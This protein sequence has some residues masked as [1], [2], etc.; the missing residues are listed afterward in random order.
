MHLRG[1]CVCIRGI[2]LQYP[3]VVYVHISAGSL[4]GIVEEGE[5]VADELGN[6]VG[7]FQGCAEGSPLSAVGAVVEGGRVPQVGEVAFGFQV[8]GVPVV[9]QGGLGLR[10]AAFGADHHHALLPSL[11]PDADLSVSLL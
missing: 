6:G 2:L 10:L 5:A 9:G 3:E 1:T 8:N 11:H 7:H 4:G